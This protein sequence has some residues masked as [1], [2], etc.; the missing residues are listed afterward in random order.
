LT[1]T[2]KS[3]RTSTR[4]PSTSRSPTLFLSMSASLRSAVCQF[5]NFSVSQPR[6]PIVPKIQRGNGGAAAELAA[7][8]SLP[9]RLTDRK[10]DRL[11]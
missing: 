3:T 7:A 9:D 4:L 6:D 1:G 8:P 10:P 11:P 2:L 5:F